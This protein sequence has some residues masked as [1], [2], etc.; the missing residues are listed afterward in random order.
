MQLSGEPRANK[1]KRMKAKRLAFAFFYF[2]E[3][4]LFKGL[5]AKK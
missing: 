3:S 5:L 2:S 1:S 4:G